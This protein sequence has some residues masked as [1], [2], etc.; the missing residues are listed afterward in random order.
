MTAVSQSVALPAGSLRLADVGYFKVQVFV[1]YP[2]KNWF[3]CKSD[4]VGEFR[5][6]RKLPES[7]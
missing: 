7:A 6:R 2:P 1:T 5:V 3:L 4:I